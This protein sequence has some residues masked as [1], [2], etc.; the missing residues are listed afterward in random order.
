MQYTPTFVGRVKSSD[1]V[2]RIVEDNVIVIDNSEYIQWDGCFAAGLYNGALKRVGTRSRAPLAFGSSLHVGLENYFKGNADYR[3]SALAEAAITHLDDLGDPRR[4]TTKLLAL[5]D[6]YTL[7]YERNRMM[8][9]EILSFDGTPGIEQSFSVPLGTVTIPDTKNLG[10]ARTVD[11]IWL[12][13]IDLV[14]KYEGAITPVDHKSTT[15]MGEKFID[16]KVRSSQMLGY[17][18]ATRSMKHLFGNLPVYGVRINAL[19]MRSTGFEFKLFDI[20]FPDWKVAEWQ[21][22]TLR[23]I[24]NLVLNLDRFLFDGIVS[25]TREHCVT[26]YGKCA[27]FDVCDSVPAMPDRMIFDENYF[28]VSTWSPLG[29]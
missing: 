4:N 9:F 17:T 12:G 20:P 15:V 22:E 5:L 1:F 16:D 6:S 19:A 8:Q 21:K 10:P 28:Y 27:S 3:D 7:E 2:K 25:P 18:F 26:K 13:K 24:E 14:T 29:E 23:A 11:V